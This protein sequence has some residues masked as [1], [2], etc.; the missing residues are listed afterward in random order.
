M[1]PT[2][3]IPPVTRRRPENE[4]LHFHYDREEREA[5]KR[6]IWTPPTGGFFRRNRALAIILVDLIIVVL[7]F[8]LYLFFLHPLEGRVRLGDYHVE[9]Q[10][11]VLAEEILITVTVTRGAD[12]ADGGEVQPVITVRVHG[13]SVS[14][15]APLP[16]RERTVALRLPRPEAT[17]TEEVLLTI[18]IGDQTRELVVPLMF[19]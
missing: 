2:D 4:E 16:G 15:L 13:E 12:R 14:D 11:Y 17:G 7:I 18:I 1:C 6:T 19:D 8:L 9:T 5:G 10:S 3:G